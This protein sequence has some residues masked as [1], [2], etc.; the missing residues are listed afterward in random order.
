MSN[1]AITEKVTV[2]GENGKATIVTKTLPPFKNFRLF[3]DNGDTMDTQARSINVADAKRYFI[4][5]ESTDYSEA[6][7]NATRKVTDVSELCHNEGCKGHYNFEKG[8]GAEVCCS[9]DDH[10]GLARC[11]C[12]WA[13]DGGNGRSQLEDLGE[14][15]EPED[16][17]FF[18]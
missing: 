17:G 1:E 7:P 4:T 3:F 2:I 15:I 8:C 13:K 12:G 16:G 5:G 10:K 11:Y 6:K 9:C 14:T 18:G